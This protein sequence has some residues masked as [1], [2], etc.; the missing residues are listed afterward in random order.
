MTRIKS[1]LVFTSML[2]MAALFAG[3]AQAADLTIISFGGA[4]QKAQRASYY[5]PFEKTG[6]AKIVAGEYNGDMAKIKAMVD[7]GY[8]TWDLVEMDGNSL[9]R[10]CEE[11]LIEKLDWSKIPSK[12]DLMPEAVS[13][14]GAGTLVWSAGI[15]YNADKLTTAPTSWAD[16]WDLEK[17]PGKRGLRKSAVHTLEFALLADGVPK[18]QVYSVLN[19]PAGVER[20]FKKLDQIKP[21]IQWWEAGAQPQQW[22]AA[23]DVVMTSAYNGRI[24]DAQRE[25]MNLK[26]VWNQSLF[27][28]DHWAIIRGSKNK[29]LA[30]QFIEFASNTANQ[31][32]FAG[33]IAYGPT[34]MPAVQ[35]LSPEVTAD[36]PTAP[37]NLEQA[38]ATNN[39]FWLDHAEDLEERFNAWAAR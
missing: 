18:D 12:K 29:A 35:S 28:L 38:L 2:S 3:A 33:E 5:E 4:I 19:T 17:F 20:A 22:L 24:K 15:A 32:V 11:G 7:T 23:G 1:S 37:A 34:N 16:F 39:E 13:E 6:A 8:V 25:G 10:S 26:L 14:C 30:Q 36:L 21:S 9:A 31:K 27:D